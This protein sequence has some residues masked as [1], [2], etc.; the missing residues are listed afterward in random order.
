[1]S[2]GSGSLL[3]GE[4]ERS[5][6]IP[7]C[8]RR[9]GAWKWR[10]NLSRDSLGALALFPRPDRQDTGARATVGTSRAALRQTAGTHAQ[11]ISP[12]LP[13]LHRGGA[14]ASPPSTRLLPVF[15]SSPPTTSPFA[16]P[17]TPCES[18]T[19][20]CPQRA[21]SLAACNVTFLPCPAPGGLV[22]S[23]SPGLTLGVRGRQLSH[24]GRGSSANAPARAQHCPPHQCLEIQ[25]LRETV[26][27]TTSESVL[28]LVQSHGHSPHL[29]RFE[30]S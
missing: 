16:P 12:P 9:R 25:Y 29:Y 6:K 19:V 24:P 11:R 30:C 5:R 1:M 26:R 10:E 2:S 18:V 27:H 28:T 23:Q 20:P 15:S 8:R 21:G 3:S 22:P 14:A 4:G 13:Q 7:S 17:G